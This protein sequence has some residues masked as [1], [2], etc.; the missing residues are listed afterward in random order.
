MGTETKKK[1]K[2][3]LP[4]I[5]VLLT[6]IIVVCAELTTLLILHRLDLLKL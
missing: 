5:F 3:K 4:H 2:F 1:K 6:A